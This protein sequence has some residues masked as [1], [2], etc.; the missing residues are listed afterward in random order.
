MG[1]LWIAN[2]VI[3]ILAML[4]FAVLLF[5]YIRSYINL[6]TKAL[7]NIMAIMAILLSDSAVA[8]VIYYTLSTKYG[9]WLASVLLVINFI[10]LI[11]YM[12]LF[13]ALNI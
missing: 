1:P 2:I 9:A 12:F 5:N 13:R 8:T 10:S 11:G 3:L 6:R 7:G 4:L